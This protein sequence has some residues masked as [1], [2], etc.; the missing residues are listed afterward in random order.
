MPHLE[1]IDP[2]EQ[3]PVL[4]PANRWHKLF[5]KSA[6]TAQEESSMPLAASLVE[7]VEKSAMSTKAK[8]AFA[9][10]KK[11]L[12]A[13]KGEMPDEQWKAFRKAFAFE[14][15]E[16]DEEEDKEELEA[17][18]EKAKK[19]ADDLAAAVETVKKSVALLDTATPDVMG[20]VNVLAPIAGVVPTHQLI[21]NLPPELRGQVEA[22]QKSA[23]ANAAALEVLQKSLDAQA[24][25]N[26]RRE[27]VAKAAADFS[28]VPG[29]AEEKAALIMAMPAAQVETLTKFLGSIE[30]AMKKSALF[31]ET[32]TAA[33]REAERHGES[34]QGGSSAYDK[35]V[36]L[37]QARVQKSAGK[38]TLAK[39]IAEIF[40]EQPELY[41][42]HDA[43]RAAID[44]SR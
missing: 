22:I 27:V 43:E 39:A 28:H 19:S 11:A 24:A 26:R 9:E 29:T 36:E 2:I 38:T 6:T 37:A 16:T 34:V 33:A 21:A 23:Q 4:L 42:Q 14:G 18:K 17:A 8:A 41:A 7:Y 40:T 15:K 30:G 12:A 10:A 20:A 13:C 31:T 3:G 32:G 1:D 25:E 5:Q 44:P 35:V